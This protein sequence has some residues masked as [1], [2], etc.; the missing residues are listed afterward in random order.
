MTKKTTETVHYL[1]L[2][3]TIVTGCGR[4]HGIEGANAKLATKDASAVTCAQC[5]RHYLFPGFASL[6]V[7]DRCN[8]VAR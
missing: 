7:L 6:L 1:P 5:K 2:D 4:A 3:Q 8:K